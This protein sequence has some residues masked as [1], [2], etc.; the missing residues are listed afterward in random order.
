MLRLIRTQYWIP[1]VKNLIR[2]TIHNCKA[3]T[4][5]RKRAQAQLM[6][7]LP[8]ERTTFSRAFTNARVDFAG[9]FDIKS[10]SGRGCRMSK[11]Y[12]CL[13]V[14]FATKAIHLE[15]TSDLSTQSFLAA[16]PRFIARRGCPKNIYSDNGTNFVGASRALRAETKAFLKDA[17]DN[18]LA[19]YAH[20]MLSWHFIPASVPHMGG[21]WEAGV[22]SFK[23]HFTKI[24]SNHKYTFEEFTTLLCRVESCLNS[25][26]LSPSS[27][28]PGD[29]EPLTPGH[30]LIGGHILAPPEIDADENR[31]SI[32][33]RWQRL[34]ALHRTFCKRWKSEYLTELQK[35]NKWRHPQ[36]NMKI[37]D[38]VIIKEDN[39]PPNEWRLGRV[40]NVHLGADNRARVVDLMTERGQVTRPVVKLVLLPPCDQQHSE[41]Q[42]SNDSTS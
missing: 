12:V 21:L 11:G 34:K 7:I 27:N 3:C 20:Q 42:P 24:A 6:G 30:F 35:R 18:T 5:Y 2:S 39:L 1:R 8:K 9:P 37:G 33:N 32:V 31:A 16:F 10:Y 23:S 15:A 22:T 38:L 36:A 26:P 28:Q 40:V 14:C 41:S 25:R 13:F 4:I 29:L 17:R 19:K